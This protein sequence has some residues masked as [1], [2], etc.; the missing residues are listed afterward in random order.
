M[1]KDIFDKMLA[2]ISRER[3]TKRLKAPGW[4]HYEKEKE[5]KRIKIRSGL[6]RKGFFVP[7]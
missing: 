5:R 1:G 3:E 2:K 4:T 6:K 7:D